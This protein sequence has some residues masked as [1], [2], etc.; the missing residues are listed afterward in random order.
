MIDA[1][2]GARSVEIVLENGVET[3][4][5]ILPFPYRL[6]S[7]ICFLGEVE[8]KLRRTSFQVNLA[9]SRVKSE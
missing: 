9:S 5:R 8:V 3:S 1:E 4:I 2:I 6:L 7:K